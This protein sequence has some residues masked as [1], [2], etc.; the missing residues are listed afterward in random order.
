[1]E[2]LQVGN[3][4]ITGDRLAELDEGRVGGGVSR[5]DVREGE[6]VVAR[7]CKRPYL[8][9]L[10]SLAMIV[11]GSYTARG[12]IVW[13]Q[14]GGRHYMDLIMMV[15][16]VPGGVWLLWEAWRRG[17]MIVLRTGNGTVRLEF[18]GPAGEQGLATLQSAAGERGFE[19]RR[20]R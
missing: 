14:H 8:L 12:V 7:I 17:P 16:L 20:R 19:L 1:M 2:P 10:I 11:L 5:A 18:K 9:S 13:W 15:L 6:I 3:I 4:L